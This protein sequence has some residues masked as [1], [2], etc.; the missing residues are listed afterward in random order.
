MSE[1][2]DAYLAYL[3][4]EDR[5]HKTTSKYETVLG[6]VTKLAEQRKVNDLAGIDLRFI[7]AYRQM[8]ADEGTAAKTRHTETTIIRQLVNFALSRDMIS[9][10]PL[11][12]LKLKKPQ[13]T[14]QPCWT[15]E[16]LQT[17]L[18]VSPEDIWPA[19]TLLAETGM[20][21]GELAW[22]TWEE[23]DLAANVFRIQPKEAWKPKSGDRRAVPISVAAKQVLKSLPQDWRWVVTM[24]PSSRR[25]ERGRQWTERRLLA[26]LK[27]VLRTLKLRG[28]LHTFRHSFISH[29]LLQQT[30]VAVVREWVGHVDEAILMLYTHIHDDASQAAMQRLGEANAQPMRK[31][32]VHDVESENGGDAN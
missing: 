12:G 27:R 8:R 24:P 10:D 28:H 21:F 16:E 19:L 3:R 7:D 15:F 18:A 30:P 4:A 5:A 2:S 17:I 1:A 31:E 22:L 32:C 11:K 14:P 9:N 25:S 6:R 23:Q 29:A 26:G 20:R 13:P